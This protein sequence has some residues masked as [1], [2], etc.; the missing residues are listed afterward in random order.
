MSV[1]ASSL[2]ALRRDQIE[3]EFRTI[4]LGTLK[5]FPSK[6]ELITLN[7]ETR[8]TKPLVLTEKGFKF[9]LQLEQDGGSAGIVIKIAAKHIQSITAYMQR[10]CPVIWI[11]P[12]QICAE[13]IRARCN[14]TTRLGPYLDPSSEATAEQEIAIIPSQDPLPFAICHSIQRIFHKIAASC[15]ISKDRFFTQISHKENN[16]KLVQCTVYMD[17]MENKRMGSAARSSAC[18]KAAL[19]T[20]ITTTA[21][22]NKHKTAPTRKILDSDTDSDFSENYELEET[23]VLTDD[24][25]DTEFRLKLKVS[26]VGTVRNI[27]TRQGNKKSSN[28]SN[29]EKE[30]DAE[31]AKNN[32]I[33]VEIVRSPEVSKLLSTEEHSDS[34]PE[35]HKKVHRA[36]KSIP[37]RHSAVSIESHLRARANEDIPPTEVI[38]NKDPEQ[39]LKSSK[40]KHSDDSDG[41]DGSAL[42]LGN[43]SSL[44][45]TV[46]NK[47]KRP[48]ETFM[49][50]GK[51]K[52]STTSSG[53]AS[54]VPDHSD[55]GVSPSVVTPAVPLPSLA[56]KEDHQVR[57]PSKPMDSK[58]QTF[59]SQF[60]SLRDSSN[61]LLAL[62][63]LCTCVI[64]APYQLNLNAVKPGETKKC[65]ALETVDGRLEGCDNPVSAPEMLRPSK[66]FPPMGLCKIHRER[67]LRHDCCPGCGTFC[68][69]GQFLVCIKNSECPHRFHRDCMLLL[70]QSRECPHCGGDLIDV[71]EVNLAPGR[72]EDLM[73]ILAGHNPEKIRQKQYLE[74]RG[75][76]ARMGHKPLVSNPPSKIPGITKELPSGMVID[77]SLMPEGPNKEELEDL[78]INLESNGPKMNQF[79]EKSFVQYVKEGDLNK[80]IQLM[81]GDIQSAVNRQSLNSALLEAIPDGSLSIIHLLVQAGADVNTSYENGDTPLLRATGE[82]RRELLIYLLTNGADVSIADDEGMTPLHYASKD[83]FVEGCYILLTYGKAKINCLDNG[84][85]SPLVWA[86]EHKQATTAKFLIH[87]GADVNIIDQEGN[88]GLHWAAL[89]GSRDI[90]WLCLQNHADINHGNTHGDTA[91]H[92]AARENNYECVTMLLAKGADPNVPNK[93]G[94]APLEIATKNSLSL[95]ALKVNSIIRKKCLIANK[96]IPYHRERILSKDLSRGYDKVPIMCVNSVDETP[97]PTDPPNGFHY[98]TENVYNSSDIRITQVITTNKKCHCIGDCTTASCTCSL[99]SEGCWY[100]KDGTLLPNFDILEPPLVFECHKLCKCNTSCRNRVVQKGIKYRLQVYRTVGMGWGLRA[101]EKIPRGAFVCD[102]VGELIS[103]AEADGREDD[104]YLFD[105]ENKDSDMFCVDARKYGNVSRF[106]NH[107]CE[108]NLVPIRVFVDHHDIRFP[109]L[110]YFSSRD[111]ESG[112][113][114][115]FD[116]GD[117]FWDVKCKQ[118]TCQCGSQRCKY[119]EEAYRQKAKKE[120]EER[121]N[122]EADGRNE[123]NGNKE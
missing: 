38:S 63:P 72:D 105:L 116:Y 17:N 84:G 96:H 13:R 31:K 61:S 69:A 67:M 41:S 123:V 64:K 60:K 49:W 24:G 5:T 14:L 68:I 19:S 99:V 102:Y 122:A 73:W 26:D 114:L 53:S 8:K 104:S 47:N 51:K 29:I 57:R 62:T 58:T 15:G 93:D 76:S 100:A 121:V 59:H 66:R 65:M 22:N 11:K 86:A 9:L 120:A 98:V 77:T 4:R 118:F 71:K 28:G 40:R 1:S 101:L 103:D 112:E 52:K 50:N 37:N 45:D 20:P 85:W 109:K 54:P 34:S 39:S 2:A 27:E 46:L 88:V 80:M 110:A 87:Y 3:L 43:E 95:V 113:E 10:G 35:Q 106:I 79:Q 119:S 6:C 12:D 89:S 83:G 107:L 111:I 74:Q 91:L 30:K 25:N 75:K 94:V 90:L 81:S 55:N 108:P 18:K 82:K 23:G 44:V 48:K 36:R 97:C 70:S 32:V 78:L 42:I 7:K 21:S 33:P 117:R 115:G 92:I 16:E 56:V